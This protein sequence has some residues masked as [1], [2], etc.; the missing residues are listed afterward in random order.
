V[1][2]VNRKRLVIP[3]QHQRRAQPISIPCW[4]ILLI[5]LISGL[6]LFLD[7]WRSAPISYHI[8]NNR[9]AR[10]GVAGDTPMPTA[11]RRSVDSDGLL[12]APPLSR[13]TGRSWPLSSTGT[14]P[15]GD[16]F[17]SWR[18]ADTSWTST[19]LRRQA[20]SDWQCSSTST[21]DILS[22]EPSERHFANTRLQTRWSASFTWLDG[23]GPL[24]PLVS[25]VTSY[26]RPG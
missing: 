24:K 5:D 7:L 10:I 4:L 14:S 18:V 3:T 6:I 12:Y 11:A 1:L 19:S 25:S 22:A 16:K 20:D 17:S 15:L 13:S 23:W 21:I 8:P 9:V 2:L 26:I